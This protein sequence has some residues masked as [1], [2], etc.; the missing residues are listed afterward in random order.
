MDLEVIRFLLTNKKKTKTILDD[1]GSKQ[2]QD[3]LK[4]ISKKSDDLIVELNKS[5][6][7]VEK[8]QNEFGNHSTI[9][10]RINSVNIM[11]ET[12]K[13]IKELSSTLLIDKNNLKYDD[14]KTICVIEYS[15]YSLSSSINYFDTSDSSITSV[16]GRLLGQ[17]VER[18]NDENIDKR[19]KE[20][21][22]Q[23]KHFE[24]ICVEF[25]QMVY[26]LKQL[27][28][29]IVEKEIIKTTKNERIHILESLKSDFNNYSEWIIK[30]NIEIERKWKYGN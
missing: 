17:F 15:F 27:Q 6:S 30:H 13:Q 2:V 23:E 26:Y 7:E 28:K 20:I 29:F 21:F 4:N 25:S 14:L 5:I 3:I 22:E 16:L 9:T 24:E 10:A 19:I 11:K 12:A 8:M 1:D 18:H